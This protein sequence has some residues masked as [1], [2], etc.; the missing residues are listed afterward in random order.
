MNTMHKCFFSLALWDFQ[1]KPLLNF[2]ICSKNET[3]EKNGLK[4]L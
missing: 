2:Q 1:I 3:P 4:Y